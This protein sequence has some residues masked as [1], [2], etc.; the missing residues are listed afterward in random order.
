MPSCFLTAWFLFQC[1]QHRLPGKGVD[2]VRRFQPALSRNARAQPQKTGVFVP[3]RVR[4]DD[5]LDALAFRIRPQPPVQIKPMRIAI[6][7]QPGARRGAGVNHRLHVDRIWLALQQ[8]PPRR[9]AEDVDKLVFRRADQ[10]PGVLRLVV[11]TE[12]ANWPPPRPIPP[13]TRRRNPAGLSKCP[14]PF[15]STAGNRCPAPASCSLIFLIS[16]ICSRSRF[17]SSPFA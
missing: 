11:A 3:V 15:P 2:H 16:L 10:P 9:M 12:R 13:A 5:A 8:Q 7:L 1:L 17:A 6:Q 4:V 14:P